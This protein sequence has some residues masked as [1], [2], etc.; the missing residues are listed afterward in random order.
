MEGF[1][2]G[3]SLTILIVL[4]IIFILKTKEINR[5]TLEL[6]KLNSEGKIEKLRLLLPNK[7][8]ENLIV[9]INTLIDDKRKMENIYK[10]KD[11]EL[12][13]AIANMSHDLRTPL[14]SIM[15]YVYLLNDD[16]LD[17]EER[18][19]YLKI[20]EKRSLV[21]NDLITNFYG[22]SRIQ[23]DQYEIKLEPVNLEL[24][25]GEIIAA[26]YE[27]LD[28]KFGE[29]E[30]NIEEGLGPVLGDKQAL[31][32]IFTNLIENII[33]HGEGE[34]KISLKKKNKYIVMEFSN[35]AEELEPKDV[36]RIF[37]K[38]FTKDRMRTG[39]NTGL[40]LAIVKLLVE[41]QGQKIEAKKVGNRLVI[42]II[43]SLES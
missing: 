14:T 38:F 10:E 8:I 6:K 27:T 12:R 5:L 21:L 7:N 2:I 43:W 31:N 34:V 3:L 40:G 23:A 15:G 30:I 36:N 17:K 4:L 13:E 29:P 42:N 24:V 18:K 11:I 20:I 35:K 37:E 33:K 19:E 32:R 9:E 28:Y 26:F 1:I 16:K 22:L 41:K 25:L 39:Q